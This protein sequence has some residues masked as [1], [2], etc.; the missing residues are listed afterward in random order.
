MFQ[1]GLIPVW[2]KVTPEGRVNLFNCEHP[3]L[4]LKLRHCR[5]FPAIEAIPKLIM[6][7][8]ARFLRCSSPLALVLFK[9]LAEAFLGIERSLE[10]FQRNFEVCGAIGTDSYGALP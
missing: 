4:N 6:T 5:I 10:R 3:K 2:T 1:W 8:C 9:L 7:L